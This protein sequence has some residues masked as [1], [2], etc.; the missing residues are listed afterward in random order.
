[1]EN[2]LVPAG[3]AVESDWSVENGLALPGLTAGHYW[4]V[5]N[6]PAA[7][8]RTSDG[9]DFVGNRAFST[10]AP[11]TAGGAS[12]RASLGPR[13]RP[14]ARGHWPR[15]PALG[16]SS[17]PQRREARGLRPRPRLGARGLGPG[18]RGPGVRLG[19]RGL[20]AQARGG[21]GPGGPR[22]GARGPRARGLGPR[23]GGPGAQSPG[24]GGPWPGA[25]DPG[26][27]GPGPKSRSPGAQGPGPKPGGAQGAARPWMG[28][29]DVFLLSKAQPAQLH[30]EWFVCPLS[31]FPREPA[32]R[33]AKPDSQNSRTRF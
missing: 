1:M 5:E 13:P 32:C 21:Q 7:A 23:P 25:W 11:L 19:A 9:F 3:I 29:V 6:G 4:S 18:A 2:G 10:V 31:N 20:G 12:P 24:P 8:G 33:T 28:Q 26:P 15:P 14:P 16:P 27:R 30:T 22:P 17:L